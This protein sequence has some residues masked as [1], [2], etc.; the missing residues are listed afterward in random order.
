MLI[1]LLLA[2]TFFLSYSCISTPLSSSCGCSTCPCSSPPVHP[3]PRPINPTIVQPLPVNP[4]QYIFSSPVPR[5]PFNMPINEPPLPESPPYFFFTPQTK[6]EDGPS[7]LNE[8]PP[9]FISKGGEYPRIPATARTFTGPDSTSSVERVNVGSSYETPYSAPPSRIPPKKTHIEVVVP[10]TTSNIYIEGKEI[11]P[12][13][14]TTTGYQ[15]TTPPP[16]TQVYVSTPGSTRRPAPVSGQTVATEQT[17]TSFVAEDDPAEDNDE[18]ELETT[19]VDISVRK[20][21][22][23]SLR[24]QIEVTSSD[25]A[26]ETNEFMRRS[27][28]DAKP[29]FL[30]YY[31]QECNGVMVAMLDNTTIL[32]ATEECLKLGCKAVNAEVHPNG[33]YTFTYLTSVTNRS[34]RKGF[35]C[36][37]VNPVPMAQKADLASSSTKFLEPA[38][39]SENPYRSRLL[40]HQ[41]RWL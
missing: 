20:S 37:S 21:N 41:T 17:Q 29:M 1:L 5:D 39:P 16:R 36:M 7:Y 15:T 14:M 40:Y 25:I 3:P 8:P 9:K 13:P 28:D 38:K 27:E 26:K 30:T 35:Y 12:K 19:T 2:D 32:R 11:A 4:S 31:N 24:K 23:S 10:M 33:R 18:S 22:H 6:I 34:N